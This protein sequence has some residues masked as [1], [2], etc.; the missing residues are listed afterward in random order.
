M[1]PRHVKQSALAGMVRVSKQAISKRCK[2]DLAPAMVGDLINL[3]HPLVAAFMRDRGVKAPSPPRAPTK[4]AKAGR[5]A[6]GAPTEPADFDDFA[7]RDP[8][9]FRPNLDA[10]DPAAVFAPG[11]PEDLE[12]IG[13]ML[14]PLIERFGTDEGC[15]NWMIALRE[16]ENIRAKRLSNEETEGQS[17]PREFVFVHI[18]GLLEE[19]NKRLL[20][21][22]PKTLVR[23]LFAMAHSG[24]T[25]SDGEREA[26][27][28]VSSHLDAVRQ[29]ISK[30]IRDAA[31]RIAEKRAG[32]DRGAGDVARGADRGANNPA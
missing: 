4:S 14:R 6:P 15:K 11:S 31:R 9:A 2:R 1:A 7:R 32:A 21:D 28:A 25:A 19:T 18:L 23:R 30:T 16:K 3:D 29:K 13:E 12:A 22:M 26:R 17:I 5:A 8:S 24:A 27:E 20:G 10:D